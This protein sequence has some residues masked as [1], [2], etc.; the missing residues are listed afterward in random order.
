MNEKTENNDRA[1]K[2]ARKVVFS[3]RGVLLIVVTVIVV[4][5]L[6]FG[7]NV[8]GLREWLSG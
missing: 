8:G 3:P 6:A 1:A 2:N 5:G 7:L 4:L